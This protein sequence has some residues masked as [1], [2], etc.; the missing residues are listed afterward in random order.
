MVG[1]GVGGVDPPQSKIPGSAPA[2][3]LSIGRLGY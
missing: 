1:G 3:P 2:R